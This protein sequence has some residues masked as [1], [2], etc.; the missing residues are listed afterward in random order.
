MLHTHTH[1]HTHTHLTELLSNIMYQS[2]GSFLTFSYF[3]QVKVKK[4]DEFI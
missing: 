4:I 1:T 3:Y 2:K